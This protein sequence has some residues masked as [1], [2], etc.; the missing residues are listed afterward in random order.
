MVGY[1]EVVATAKDETEES[2]QAQTKDHAVFGTEVVDDE[3]SEEGAGNVKEVF[4]TT[5]P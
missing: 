1:Q 3:R 2:L 4:E 5:P